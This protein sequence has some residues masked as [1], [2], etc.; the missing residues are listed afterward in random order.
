[1]GNDTLYMKHIIFFRV[2]SVVLVSAVIAV[3]VAS[4]GILPGILDL[5]V[6]LW[7][8]NQPT[9]IQPYLI[10]MYPETNTVVATPQV[11]GAPETFVYDE[12]S[13]EGLKTMNALLVA[14]EANESNPSATFI[15]YVHTGQTFLPDWIS[16]TTPPGIIWGGVTVEGVSV[17]ITVNQNVSPW[18][19][20]ASSSNPWPLQAPVFS[21][22]GYAPFASGDILYAV[23]PDAPQAGM[24]QIHKWERY[25]DSITNGI[26]V[27][28][29]SPS[30]V[31]Y[32]LISEV[33]ITGGT[34]ATSNDFIEIYNPTNAPMNLGGWKLRKQ[35]AAGTETSIAV[36]PATSTI[37][38][39]GFFLWANADNG[40]AASIGAD[41]MNGNT[42][43]P[44][45]GI[46]LLNAGNTVIDRVGWGTLA[47]S[48]TFFETNPIAAPLGANESYERKAWQGIICFSATGIA[49]LLGNGC[50]QGNNVSDFD[51]RS[52]SEPQNTASAREP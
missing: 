46:A 7:P 30:N 42:I 18:M 11:S 4:A 25:Q 33:Q 41:V 29:A 35:T 48:S 15:E 20:T 34:G 44:D 32:P 49:A 47:A 37:P 26:Y 2:A 36:F 19:V 27:A 1:M 17:Q 43:A 38:A 50:D 10:E 16:T 12:A 14:L 21:Q 23:E 6:I 52:V 28:P 31:A 39:Y 5:G 24:F 22:S 51:V 9:V 8:P 13:G 3:G 45:N 40:Y